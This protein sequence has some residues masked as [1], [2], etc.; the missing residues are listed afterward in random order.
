MDL[1]PCPFCGSDQLE[2]EQSGNLDFRITCRGDHQGGW[3]RTRER[4]IKEWNTRYT[5]EVRDSVKLYV[6]AN[7]NGWNEAVM[8]IQREMP[9]MVIDLRNSDSG[10]GRDWRYG[11]E[12]L[13]E[14]IKNF[15]HE[16]I[17]AY[18]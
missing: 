1:K 12:D 6:E 7:T 11:V 4:A 9:T 10:A 15:L 14:S 5:S 3:A 17:R 13:E 16:M 2:I 8:K 18:E